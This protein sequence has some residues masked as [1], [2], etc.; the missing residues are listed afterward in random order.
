[1][2]TDQKLLPVPRG[3]PGE[4]KERRQDALVWGSR[5]IPGT[6]TNPSEIG[7]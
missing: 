1:M 3:E 2:S 5:D 6:H 7:V 4:L